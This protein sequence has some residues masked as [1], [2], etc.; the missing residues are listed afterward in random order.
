[1][2]SSSRDKK[3]VTTVINSIRITA[4]MLVPQHVAVTVL[5]VMTSPRV[6]KVM[7]P[8]MMAI[9]TSVMDAIINVAL[10]SVVMVDSIKAK[11]VMMAIAWRLTHVRVDAWLLAV[12]TAFGDKIENKGKRVTKLAM[13]GI[14]SIPTA[15]ATRA[16]HHVAGMAW[17]PKT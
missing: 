2:G 1:M 4:P 9:K 13:M 6:M 14:E 7:K 8:A 15:V 17:L 16:L 10:S 3:R 5:P 11:P 12:V